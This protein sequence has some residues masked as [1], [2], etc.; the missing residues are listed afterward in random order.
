MR[1]T[2][3]VIF[4]IIL[5]LLA[6]N[7]PFA[8][9]TD[10]AQPEI[11]FP[12]QQATEGEREVMEAQLFGLLVLEG[13]CL[14]VTAE[15]ES[16]LIIWPPGY[17]LHMDNESIT[18]LDASGMPAVSLGQQVYISG[19]EIPLAD[20]TIAAANIDGL[21]DSGC[22]GPYWFAGEIVEPSE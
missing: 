17:T 7:L 20:N 13:S 15:N 19:G 16:Y 3:T 6:C 4:L 14:R 21:A 9:Q 12:S 22:A 11:A 8:T 10:S 1:R 18:I 5:S 2:T